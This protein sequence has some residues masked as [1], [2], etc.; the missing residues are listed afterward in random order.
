MD[1]QKKFH[2]A[3]IV[4]HYFPKLPPNQMALFN[5]LEDIYG[6]WNTRI[7]L[8]SRKD[9][10]HLYLHHVLHGLAIAKVITFCAHTKILDFG[11][12]GGFPG[13]PL[14]IMFPEVNFHLVD[15]TAK[16]IKAVESIVTT[17]GLKNITVDWARGEDLKGA[18]D[19]VIGRG[20]THL[21]L[22]YHWVKDKIAKENKNSLYN[23][24]LY[25]KGPSPDPLPISMDVYP[26]Q[27]FFIEPFFREKYLIHGY[28]T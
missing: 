17:L 23:G 15:A 1:L 8:I 28:T 19:F 25:L 5:R 14:A 21:A 11:T 24:I 26:L 3:S 9:I 13:I 18:Y 12:G 27:D 4:S 6:H 16:K 22:F 2:T 10:A 7:N 20:V